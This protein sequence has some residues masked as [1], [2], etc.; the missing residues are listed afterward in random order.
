MEYI[1]YIKSIPSEEGRN[2]A[3]M[4]FRRLPEEAEK[5]LLQASPPLA[6]RAINMNITLFRWNRA[7]DLALKYKTH[8]DTVL[9][10]RQ[11]YLDEFQRDETLPKF[12]Q[13]FNQVY[14]LFVFMQVI[15]TTV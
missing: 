8:V 10:Y 13:Y 1:Q 12:I 7:L 2:A 5:I 6:Y 3:V 15:L 9:G 14:K 11:R 4:L